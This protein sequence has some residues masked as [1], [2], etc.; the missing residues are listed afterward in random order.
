[1]EINPSMFSHQ[2]VLCCSSCCVGFPL[3][4]SSGGELWFS[5]SG[6]ETQCSHSVS[7]TLFLSF[8]PE[9]SSLRGELGLYIGG[10]T[11]T[12]NNTCNADECGERERER[13]VGGIL[14]CCV[15]Q[16]PPKAIRGHPWKC[17]TWQKL[18]WR[19]MM[20]IIKEKLTNMAAKMME[21]WRTFKPNWN[22]QQYLSDY[23]FIS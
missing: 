3:L 18:L 23:V 9:Q 4:C 21:I 12:P 6:E 13:K 7:R 11:Q 17:T 14:Q 20:E 16:D 2:T 8:C 10:L 15:A 19:I 1:M 22:W 5:G